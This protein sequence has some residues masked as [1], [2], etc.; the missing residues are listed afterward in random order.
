MWSSFF[1]PEILKRWQK[2]LVKC[3]KC[4]SQLKQHHIWRETESRS[5]AASKNMKADRRLKLAGSAEILN[6]E[7]A[8]KNKWIRAIFISIIEK[9]L[10]FPRM[11]CLLK[12][13]SKCHCNIRISSKMTLRVLLMT[14]QNNLPHQVQPC[15]NVPKDHMAMQENRI[16]H[17]LFSK[18]I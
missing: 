18:S 10:T 9:K 11:S 1:F 5:A 13:E 6:T 4:C 15:F 8:E 3:W 7:L 2:C 14:W 17:E 12:L 16:L